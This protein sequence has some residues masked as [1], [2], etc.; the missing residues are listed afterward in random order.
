MKILD[1]ISDGIASKLS[2]RKVQTI[3]VSLDEILNYLEKV[4]EEVETTE[5]KNIEKVLRGWFLNSLRTYDTKNEKYRIVTIYVGALR[6]KRLMNDVSIVD[7]ENGKI[8]TYK[9]FLFN[10][11]FKKAAKQLVNKYKMQSK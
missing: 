8:Y 2:G 11:K 1:K 5:I 7:I 6:S 4:L 3:R 9:S 10:R